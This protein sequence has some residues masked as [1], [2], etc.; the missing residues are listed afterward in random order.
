MV[1]EI[2]FGAWGI[3]GRTAGDTSYG[4]TDD[5]LSLA[6]LGEALDRGIAFFDT[7]S[8]YGNG[9]SEELIGQAFFWTAQS[10]RDCD[11]SRLRFMGSATG[12]LR[13]S[14]SGVG[15]GEP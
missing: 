4:E 12:L 13:K 14:H 3:G 8:A 2:G 9:H 10:G 7:S 6:A 1:S 5:R 11:Q 15:R